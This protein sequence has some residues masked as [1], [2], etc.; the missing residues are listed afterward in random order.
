MSWENLSSGFP[1]RSDTNRVV[2]RQKMA[3]GLELRIYEAEG[4]HYLCS[5]NK[6]ADQLRSYL[7]CALFLHR[8]V[9]CYYYDTDQTWQQ[10]TIALLRLGYVPL[11]LG[12]AGGLVVEVSG[13]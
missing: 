4:L 9:F 1:T 11:L 10:T 2:Q 5:E 3:R 13:S 8:Q 6:G 7:I 12:R